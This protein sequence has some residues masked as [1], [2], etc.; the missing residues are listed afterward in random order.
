MIS[1]LEERDAL[2]RDFA[3]A[4]FKNDLDALYRVV[5]PEFR[6]DY[7]DGIS[8]TKSLVGKEAIGAHLAEQKQL[9]SAQGYHPVTYYHLPDV[10]FMT[11]RVSETIRATGVQRDQSGVELYTFRDGKIATKDVYRKPLA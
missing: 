3:K 4:F 7:Y 1:F 2:F 5:I 9:F 10:S 8:L 11:F 6:W